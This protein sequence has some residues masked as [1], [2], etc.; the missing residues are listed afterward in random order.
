MLFPPNY[1]LQEICIT[2]VKGFN[3]V[4]Q[5]KMHIARSVRDSRIGDEK[6]EHGC[7]KEFLDKVALFGKG[8]FFRFL[9]LRWS[10]RRISW[11]ESV[12]TFNNC[13]VINS[14]PSRHC[15]IRLICTSAILMNIRQYSH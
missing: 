12:G 9:R 8:G 15:A 5:G 6:N 11:T 10:C 1:C 4:H 7:Q 13:F 14:Y 2:I 3:L